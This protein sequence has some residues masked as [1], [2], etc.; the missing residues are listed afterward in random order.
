[1]NAPSAELLRALVDGPSLLTGVEWHE[2]ID[3]TMRRAAELAA[4]GHPEGWAVLADVQTAGRGRRGR[5][6]TSPGGTS[7]LCSL[8]LRP[9]VPPS[10]LPL[11]GLLAGVALAACA[12]AYLAPERV[13]LKWPNDVLVDGRKAAG[14]LLEAVAGGGAVLGL[15]VNVDWRGVERPAELAGATSLAEAAAAPVDRW[16]ILAA[17]AGVFG[18]RYA[19]WRRA[20]GAFLDEYR[21]RCATLGSR[22]RVLLPAR[23]EPLTGVAEEIAD[24]GALVLRVGSGERREVHAGDIE[25]LRREA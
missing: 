18:N 15:G 3:S 17:F 22:V 10:A 6:W 8:V 1:M 21:T 9:A 24:S 5:R 19:A 14:L 2:E 12:D 20:P 11:L 25:H 7:L 16:R 4:D 13:A 23:D